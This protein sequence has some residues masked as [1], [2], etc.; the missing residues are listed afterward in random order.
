MKY[1]FK[2]V[3]KICNK[4]TEGPWETTGRGSEYVINKNNFN[5]CLTRRSHDAQFI[6]LARTALPEF[7]Q[8]VIELEDENAKLR[9]VAEAAKGIEWVYGGDN[10]EGM[11]LLCPCCGKGEIDGHN[12]D[13]KL[14]QALVA[15]GYGGEE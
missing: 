10:L 6:A 1:D 5:V 15:A 4:A 7:A 13:C 3:L 9:A 12:D 11:W 8:R 14:H 2:E